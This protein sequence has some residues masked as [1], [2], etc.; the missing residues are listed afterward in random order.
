MNNVK[1]RIRI[2]FGEGIE[3]LT[4]RKNTRNQSKHQRQREAMEKQYREYYSLQKK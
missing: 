1:R 2:G 4:N 3:W